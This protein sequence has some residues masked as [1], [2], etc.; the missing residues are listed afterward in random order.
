[1]RILTITK[2]YGKISMCNKTQL[3]IIKAFC[4][5]YKQNRHAF[6]KGV[7]YAVMKVDQTVLKETT[8]VAVWTIVLSLLMQAVFLFLHKWDYTVLLG[9]LWGGAVSVL[10]FFCMGLF[11]QKAVNTDQDEARK[12]IKL[13]HSLRTLALFVLVVIGVWLPCFSPLAVI[14]SLFFSRIGIFIK[15]FQLKQTKEATNQH[16]S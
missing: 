2:K 10:N 1:M 7:V 15:A 3:H 6:Q 8:Y 13:S 9:N 4:V 14:L 16:E 12:I 11:I 5:N